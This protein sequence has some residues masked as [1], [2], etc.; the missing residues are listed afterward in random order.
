MTYP[1]PAGSVELKFEFPVSTSPTGVELVFGA[2]VVYGEPQYMVP[3]SVLHTAYGTPE[4]KDPW[5]RVPGTDTSEFGVSEVGSTIP[6]VSPAGFDS[7]E[8]GEATIAEKPEPTQVSLNSGGPGTGGVD[9]FVSGDNFVSHYLRYVEVEYSPQ[10]EWG[11]A[12]IGDRYQNVRPDSTPTDTYGEPEVT[13]PKQLAP[14]GLDAAQYGDAEVGFL[15]VAFPAGLAPGTVSQPA[16]GFRVRHVLPFAQQYVAWGDHTVDLW[17][18][19]LLVNHPPESDA[20]GELYGQYTEIQNRNKTVRPVGLLAQ[21]IS[22][23]PAYLELTGRAIQPPSI[24][25]GAFG[26]GTFISY[27]IRNMRVF[28]YELDRYPNNTTVYNYAATIRV[29]DL[30][31]FVAGTPAVDKLLKFVTVS[32]HRADGYGTQWA[33][34]SPRSIRPAGP[35]FIGRNN[36]HYVSHSP[37]ITQF[38]GFDNLRTGAPFVYIRPP[39]TVYAS[40]G[41]L[42]VQDQKQMGI[43]RVRRYPP[44]IEV[45]GRPYTEFSYPAAMVDFRVRSLQPPSVIGQ[46]VWGNNVVRDRTFTVYVGGIGTTEYGVAEVENAIVVLIP[47]TTILQPVGLDAISWGDLVV[48][49]RWLNPESAGDTSQFGDPECQGNTILFAARH[50]PSPMAG[51]TQFGLTRVPGWQTVQG[52]YWRT[53]TAFGHPSIAPF[54]VYCTTY[55]PTDYGANLAQGDLGMDWGD[56]DGPG[57]GADLVARYGVPRI[58]HPRTVHIYGIPGPAPNKAEF[59]QHTLYHGTQEVRPLGFAT[60]RTGTAE[61]RPH[62]QELGPREVPST[63]YGQLTVNVVAPPFIYPIPTDHF[64]D[65]QHQVGYFHQRLYVTGLDSEVVGSSPLYPGH[66]NLVY[67]IVGDWLRV[68][69]SY[70]ATEYGPTHVSNYI[71]YVYPELDAD[72]WSEWGKF[73]VRRMIQTAILKGNEQTEFGVFDNTRETTIRPYSVQFLCPTSPYTQVLHA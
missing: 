47:T 31:S 20:D 7:S 29:N 71:R 34:F 59:G 23:S 52:V 56:I 60:L 8:F 66:N 42:W 49:Q 9:G 27:R 58:V 26:D 68:F 48:Q 4:V 51:W 64:V 70:D 33:S 15:N 19:Y 53:P 17:Q 69:P 55:V 61:L 2:T 73:S 30:S 10:E 50:H 12:F 6:N 39:I 57:T 38:T 5:V 3:G 22:T 67:P 14:P 18:R 63:D 13:F 72:E 46:E 45:P 32:G 40:W 43:P 36:A 25:D 16:V 62:T 11:I 65:G 41:Q 1:Q 44:L 28:G 21:R 37:Y 24:D 35:D 54:H